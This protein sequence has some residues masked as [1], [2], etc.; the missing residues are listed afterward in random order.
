MAADA[1][2]HAEASAKRRTFLRTIAREEFL[3]E[4]HLD[5]HGRADVAGHVAKGLQLNLSVAPG[6]L[7][8]GA[9]SAS[10]GVLNG[11]RMLDNI[12]AMG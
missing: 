7:E 9:T 1:R 2:T 3:T 5:A 11:G 12:H 8:R 10:V 4:A 6:L